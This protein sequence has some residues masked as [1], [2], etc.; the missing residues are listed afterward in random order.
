MKYPE[1]AHA[2]SLHSKLMSLFS[3]DA[4]ASIG[5]SGAGVHWC[6]TAQRRDSH[7]AV[8]CFDLYRIGPEYLTYFN[9][10]EEALAIGR[11][12]SQQDTLSAVARWLKG[13][14]RDDLYAEFPFVDQ[15]K[16][17]LLKIIGAI[18]LS[19]PRLLAKSQRRLIDLGSGLHRLRIESEIRSV[20]I[21]YWG[22]NALPDIKFQW[23][24]CLLF[25]FQTGDHHLL[26]NI[27]T[28]WLCDEASPS[29]LRYEYPWLEIGALADYYERGQPIEGEFIKSWQDIGKFYDEFQFPFIPKVKNFL[30]QMI[31]AGFNRTLRAGQSVTILILS[32]ARRHGLNDHH[33]RIAFHFSDDGMKIDFSS[34]RG[35]AESSI[36]VPEIALTPEIL[37]LLRNLESEPIN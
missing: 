17:D 29:A 12:T 35:E 3:S 6:C 33:S 27:L 30:I 24:D 16:R 21:S 11:S 14:A 32:R 34:K 9:R 15:Q 23:N 18:A 20:E 25:Q 8:H 26:I 10:N 5:I 1:E 2:T 36:H 22:K 13:I 31:S 37:I 7:C 28:R 4:S 19:S